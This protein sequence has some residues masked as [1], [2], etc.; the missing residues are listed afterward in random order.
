MVSAADI[1][2]EQLIGKVS[3]DLKKSI[4]AP[5]W[6]DFVKTGPGRQRPPENEDWWYTRAASVL[7][8]V[9]MN[10][11][12]GINRLRTWYGNKKDR[13]VR[14]E[15]RYPAGGKIIREILNQLEGLGYVKKTKRGR[16]ITPKGQSYLDT[17]VKVK[18]NGAK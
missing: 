9:Y 3:S 17:S 8:K 15:K 18:T 4:K 5:E 7:R 16:E 6:A 2:A 13:G 12:V 1:P 14:P 11:P 10:G